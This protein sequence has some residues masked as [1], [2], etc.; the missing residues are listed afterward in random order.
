MVLDSEALQL[1]GSHTAWTHTFSPMFT[2][3]SLFHQ[4]EVR[5]RSAAALS[6]PTRSPPPL[7]L[8]SP[9]LLL[10]RLEAA[11][12]SS[13]HQL[14]SGG[15]RG[16]RTNGPEDRRQPQEARRGGGDDRSRLPTALWLTLLS[17]S[18]PCSHGGDAH[19]QP[20]PFLAGVRAPGSADESQ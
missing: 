17:L 3:P 13:S 15:V 2:L 19:L 8:L 4:G 9:A 12:R 5:L 14:S 1:L 20:Q 18:L 16:R 10:P 7:L 11:T 6:S